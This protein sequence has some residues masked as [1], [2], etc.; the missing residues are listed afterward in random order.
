MANNQ[1]KQRGTA[2]QAKQ[3]SPME[4][5]LDTFAEV[6]DSGTAKMDSSELCESEKRFNQIADRVVA[7]KRR[8]ETA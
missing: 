7:R 8:R 3:E 1:H 4:A 5:L 2:P 6:I